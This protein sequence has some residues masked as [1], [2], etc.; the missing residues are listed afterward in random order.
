MNSKKTNEKRSNSGSGNKVTGGDSMGKMTEN[1]MKR[2]QNWMRSNN[3]YESR[4]CWCFEDNESEKDTNNTMKENWTPGSKT[5]MKRCAK[6]GFWAFTFF[7][8]ILATFFLLTYFLT[9]EMVRFLWLVITGCFLG[10]AIIFLVIITGWLNRN[11]R[12]YF[13]S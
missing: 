3:S 12:N 6:G 8:L 5:R 1:W 10:C 7:L 4:S 13:K 2:C 11:R 9:P